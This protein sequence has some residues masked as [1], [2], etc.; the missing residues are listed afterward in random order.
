MHFLHT[1]NELKSEIFND[2][3]SYLTKMFV[4]VITKNS[5]WEVLTKNLLTFKW[6]NGDNDENFDVMGFTEN[7]NF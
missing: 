5:N 1:K 2:K 3:N 4:S 6:W 7:S